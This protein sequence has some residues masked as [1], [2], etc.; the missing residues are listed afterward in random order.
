VSYRGKSFVSVL[1]PVRC[2]RGYYHC[3][4]CQAGHFPWDTVL[5]LSAP[6]LTPGAEQL[7]SLA[8]CLD[9]FGEGH[10]KIWL[11]GRIYGCN[12]ERV[13]LWAWVF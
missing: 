7:V 12:L 13:V 5:G 1:G 8:G 2:E 9:S 6:E 11:V 10:K 4:H 3:P